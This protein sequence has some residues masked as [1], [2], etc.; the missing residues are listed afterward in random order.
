MKIGITN[1]YSWGYPVKNNAYKPRKLG[2]LSHVDLSPI[3]S[4]MRFLDI[5]NRAGPMCT[6]RWTCTLCLDY[7]KKVDLDK[8]FISIICSIM[9]YVK[10]ANKRCLNQMEDLAK[11]VLIYLLFRSMYFLWMTIYL[12]LLVSLSFWF[13]DWN[14]CLYK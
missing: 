12:Y 7:L 10:T 14:F 8:N 3:F 11:F 1:Y 13:L 5:F 4:N 2:Y 9:I 6:V